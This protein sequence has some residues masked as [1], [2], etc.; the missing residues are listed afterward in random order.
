M[1][2]GRKQSGADDT[3]GSG[4]NRGLMDNVSHL[5]SFPPVP[6]AWWKPVGR[7]VEVFLSLGYPPVDAL[8]KLSWWVFR[9][10]RVPASQLSMMDPN[11]P[12]RLVLAGPVCCV[13][14]TRA[15]RARVLPAHVNGDHSAKC[16]VQVKAS[17]QVNGVTHPNSTEGRGVVGPLGPDQ[18]EKLEARELEEVFS[19]VHRCCTECR[20]VS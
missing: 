18:G 12:I 11:L 20:R 1:S 19:G 17:F 13:R 8:R 4:W 16:K 6:T 10:P 3:T 14:W 15:L 9:C 2:L 7:R 5:T